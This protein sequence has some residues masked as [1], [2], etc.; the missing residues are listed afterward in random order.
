MAESRRI[1]VKVNGVEYEREVDP[2]RLLLWIF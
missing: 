2:K 1:V